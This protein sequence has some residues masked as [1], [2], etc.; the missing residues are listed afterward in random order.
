[1]RRAPNHA[2]HC[3][4]KWKATTYNLGQKINHNIEVDELQ[5]GSSHT[6]K[7]LEPGRV[8]EETQIKKKR[9]NRSLPGGLHVGTHDQTEGGTLGGR[10][11]EEAKEKNKVEKEDASGE[12]KRRRK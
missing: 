8:R 2:H 11:Q 12:R 7:M 1:M 4:Q 6:R 5:H 10:N 3:R 9:S